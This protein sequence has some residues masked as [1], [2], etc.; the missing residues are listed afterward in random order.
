MLVAQMPN[1]KLFVALTTAH[2]CKLSEVNIELVQNFGF[3]FG[4]SVRFAHT[5]L[6]LFCVRNYQMPL[7]VS[8][9]ISSLSINYVMLKFEQVKFYVANR[10][11]TINRGITV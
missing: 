5:S 2:K 8:L 9:V 10:N 11:N 7:K 6:F 4:K 1:G 3:T